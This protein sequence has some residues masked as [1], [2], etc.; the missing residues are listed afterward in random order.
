M[1][2]NPAN[3]QEVKGVIVGAMTVADRS[4]VSDTPLVKISVMF[5]AN[6]HRS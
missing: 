5:E 4:A 6:L 1:Q 3:L 2:R